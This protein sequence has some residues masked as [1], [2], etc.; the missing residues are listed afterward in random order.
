MRYPKNTWIA[1]VFLTP[2]LVVM[3]V[4]VFYPLIKGISYSFTNM[5]QY[6]M[7]SKFID[8]SYE[9]V[10]LKN[11]KELFRSFIAPKSVFRDV[12]IQTLIWTFVNVFFH[13][14]IGL[15]LALL[16]H[17]K[18]K[19]RGIYRTLLMVPWAVPSFVGAFAWLWMYNDKYGF[20]NLMLKQMGLATIPWLGDSFWAMVSVIMVNVW[21]GVPF[22][23]VTLL[24]GLQ[25]IPDSLY[26][27][28][29]I[30]GASSWQQFRHITLPLLRPVAVT[31]TTLGIIWTFNMF[32]IIYLVTAGGPI[33]STEIL[34]TYAYREAFRNWNLGLASTYG[35]V[36]LSFLLVFTLIYRRVLKSNQEVNY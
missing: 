7:G 2:V 15:G 28:A 20:F 31:A 14:T 11:Y 26:E 29:R 4:L 1:Y 6:N 3:A 35:V 30:D 12:L 18:I 27:A 32:N 24:G 33:H 13:F 10:G 9:W 19:G 21:I 25:S 23:I 5:N 22:M 36:I 34:V 16:L 17:R 8:P